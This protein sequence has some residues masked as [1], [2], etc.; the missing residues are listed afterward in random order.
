LRRKIED[1]QDEGV[2]KYVKNGSG[3]WG[4]LQIG[5]SKYIREI[6]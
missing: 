4:A 2:E 5:N 6:L 1:L 3:I